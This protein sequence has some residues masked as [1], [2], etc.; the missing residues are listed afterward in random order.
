MTDATENERVA[1]MCRLIAA[2]C[3]A[4]K[5]FMEAEVAL[6]REVREEIRKRRA[7]APGGAA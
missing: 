3:A 6:E 7:D 4:L 1:D 2:R 5:R